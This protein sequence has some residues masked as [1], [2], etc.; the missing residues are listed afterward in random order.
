[1]MRCLRAAIMC[2]RTNY[3]HCSNSNTGACCLVDLL[4][5]SFG[6]LLCFSWPALQQHCNIDGVECWAVVKEYHEQWQVQGS[7]RDV[8]EVY[9]SKCITS[10]AEPVRRDGRAGHGMPALMY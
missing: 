9:S 3:H 8:F 5:R 4:G 2:G 10:E 6:C 1:M 7:C